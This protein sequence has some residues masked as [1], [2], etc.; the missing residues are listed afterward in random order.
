MNHLAGTGSI[1]ILW[2]LRKSQQETLQH[3]LLTFNDDQRIKI[4]EFTLQVEVL[5]YSTFIFFV[6]LVVVPVSLFSSCSFFLC[7]RSCRSHSSKN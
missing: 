2:S 3:L 1:C 7:C 6:L 4:V 5:K